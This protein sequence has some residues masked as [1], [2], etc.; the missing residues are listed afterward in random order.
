MCNICAAGGEWELLLVV[1]LLLAWL[2]LHVDPGMTAER[3]PV[4]VAEQV[5]EVLITAVPLPEAHGRHLRGVDE[6][7]DAVQAAFG[8]TT[9]AEIR[10]NITVGELERLLACLLYT[11]PSPRDS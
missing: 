11:S 8:G 10:S 9:K 7:A 2:E 1:V 5:P 6:E 4:A 3:I